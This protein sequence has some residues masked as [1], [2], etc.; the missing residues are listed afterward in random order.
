MAILQDITGKINVVKL[1][2]VF[3]LKNNSR[4]LMRRT[5]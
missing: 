2:S 1:V 4:Y 5:K 3:F